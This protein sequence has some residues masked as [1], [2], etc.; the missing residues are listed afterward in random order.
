MQIAILEDHELFSKGLSYMISSEIPNSN[1]EIYNSI[2]QISNENI[3]FSALDLL[4]S[5]IE[6]PGEDVFK[7]FE[8]LKTKHSNLPILVISMHDKYSVIK[9]C[10]DIGVNG[11]LLKDDE[12]SLKIVLDKLI[13]EGQF[14][15]DRV[16]QTLEKMENDIKSLLSPREELILEK[17]AD[18]KSVGEIADD[19]CLSSLT[20][21]THIRNIKVKLGFKKVNDLVIFY[22]KN[23]IK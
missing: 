5:D 20:V 10:R 23:Y 22:N 12:L 21:K 16:M 13:N 11:Y 9:K 8:K 3:D 17:I 1:V 2:Q 19:V 14:Y 4:I 15:S 18:G 7:L 6:L